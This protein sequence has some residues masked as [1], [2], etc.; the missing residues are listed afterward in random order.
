M[1]NDFGLPDMAIEAF[2]KGDCWALALALHS[3]TGW[4][5]VTIS[6]SSDPM[7]WSHV[8]VWTPAGTV[9]D[10]Q[11][12]WTAEEWFEQWETTIDDDPIVFEWSGANGEENHADFL[13]SVGDQDRRYLTYLPSIWSERVLAAYTVKV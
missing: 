2:T 8:G 1:K 4:N 11:G 3:E 9:L 10:I 12:E 7:W 5:I 13:A 6:E